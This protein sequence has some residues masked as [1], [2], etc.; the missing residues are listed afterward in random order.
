MVNYI[1][2]DNWSIISIQVDYYSAGMSSLLRE[3][4]TKIRIM[5]I[6]FFIIDL[7]IYI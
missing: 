3:Y 4:F 7:K 2:R 5:Y 1:T 6:L